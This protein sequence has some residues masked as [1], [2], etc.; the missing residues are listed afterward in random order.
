MSHVLEHGWQVVVVGAGSCDCGTSGCGE[1]DE[2]P[3]FAYT[4]GL[5]HQLGHPELVMSGQRAELMHRALNA[6][7]RM[8]QQGHDFKA[9]VLTEDVID[10]FAVLAEEL[11]PDAC[12][13]LLRCSWWFHR[14]PV[15]GIQL[16]WPDTA[17]VWPWQPGSAA[18]APELQP[19]Q[20]RVPAPRNG[21]LAPD[22]V[23]PFPIAPDELAWTCR[24]VNQEGAPV[25]LVAR[26][27]DDGAEA[28]QLLCSA[29]HQEDLMEV[30]ER[31]HMAHLVRSA[32]SLY[33]L[34]RLRA[35]ERAWR[36]ETWH[37]WQTAR[38]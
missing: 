31:V 14:W 35:G 2:G 25:S 5:P 10:R 17:G 26:D 36:A 19:E 15:P 23:W 18:S 13:E 33:D 22:P 21:P 16:V 8:V 30:V 27:L 38:R 29:G 11:T 37:P 3:A 4:V 1:E 7:A 34:A 24:C 20:W 28:W 32:P 6:A 9:G 12:G